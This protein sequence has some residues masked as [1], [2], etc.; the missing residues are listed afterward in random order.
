MQESMSY[1]AI[2]EEKFKLEDN[3]GWVYFYRSNTSHYKKRWRT[4]FW[5][6]LLV[7]NS[8]F[9]TYFFVNSTAI[10]PAQNQSTIKCVIEKT[11]TTPTKFSIKK[12]MKNVS[13][14]PH[15][16]GTRKIL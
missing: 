14:R 7:I 5:I 9:S 10:I 3:L 8:A 13:T 4:T 6:S 1:L 16:S 12:E 15:N 11:F 2:L